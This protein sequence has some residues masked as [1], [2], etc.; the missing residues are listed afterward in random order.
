MRHAIDCGAL[1]EEHLVTLPVQN[2][3]VQY[4]F[5]VY[6]TIKVIQGHP[7]YLDEHLN[8]LFHSAAGIGLAHPYTYNLIA[9]WVALLIATDAIKEAT[10]RILLLGTEVPRL[11]ISASDPLIYPERYYNEGVQAISYQ[12][13]RFLPQY[14]TCSLLLN[15]L[16]L[17]DAQRQGA[18]EALLVDRNGRVLEGTRSNFY[19]CRGDEIWTAG[20]ELVLAGVTRDKIIRAIDQLGYTIRFEPVPLA[21]VQ[22]GYYEE[23]FISSTSMQAMPLCSLD[24]IEFPRNYLRTEAIRK[25][26]GQWE[27]LDLP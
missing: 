24:G 17:R 6:E 3:E 4:G 26:I 18:F 14:K 10:L 8:R 20:D 23:L 2:R 13:E 7:L 12:G 27:A 19:A 16:A 22:K 9:S 25:L 1:I 5:G 15:Y 21:S 11:I